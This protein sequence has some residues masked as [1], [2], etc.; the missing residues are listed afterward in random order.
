MQ[1][2]AFPDLVIERLIYGLLHIDYA[3]SLH[4]TVLVTLYVHSSALPLS[5]L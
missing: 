4:A 5:M 3:S 1:R 2:T